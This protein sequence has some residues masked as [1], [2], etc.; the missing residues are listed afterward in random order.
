MFSKN[1]SNGNSRGE[2]VGGSITTIA[3]G[4][5]VNGD[6]ECDSDMRVDG[7]IIGNVY[8]KS[9]IVLGSSGIIQGDLQAN[10]ADVF[11]TINGNVTTQDLAILK[12]KCTI[13]GNIT[14]SRLQIDAEAIFNGHCKMTSGGQQSTL[15]PEKKLELQEQEN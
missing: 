7:N 15:I 14:T 2:F 6:I 8:C 5:T 4:T 12:S 3:E 13:N 1:K 10:N 11:G 9:K